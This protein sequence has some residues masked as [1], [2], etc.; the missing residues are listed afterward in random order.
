MIMRCRLSLW[1]L[2]LSR[3]LVALSA[4][5]GPWAWNANSASTRV[6]GLEK[7]CNVCGCY[8][9]WQL[10]I[11]IGPQVMV[12]VRV[13]LLLECSVAAC[14]GPFSFRILSDTSFRETISW[15]AICELSAPTLLSLLTPAGHRLC[16]HWSYHLV[17]WRVPTSVDCWCAWWQ[18]LLHAVIW[19]N[20]GCKLVGF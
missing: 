8:V 11:V 3:E 5:S 6:C 16:T 13:L 15:I 19:W 7:R 17:P 1:C 18:P 9:W 2:A 4:R 12:C 20:S 14:L 10:S